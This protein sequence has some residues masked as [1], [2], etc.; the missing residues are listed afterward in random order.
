MGQRLPQHPPAEVYLDD[1]SWEFVLPK[2]PHCTEE[3][4][5]GSGERGSDPRDALG[6]RVAHCDPRKVKDA[7]ALGYYLVLPVEMSA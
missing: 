5:H 6:H 3:H 1:E 7:W 2:C 4:R